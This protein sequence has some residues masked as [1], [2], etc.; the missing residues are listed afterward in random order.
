MSL[1]RS[2]SCCVNHYQKVHTFNSGDIVGSAPADSAVLNPVKSVILAPV[3]R[4]L[5]C[6]ISWST[7]EATPASRPSRFLPLTFCVQGYDH[8]IA[9]SDHA[10]GEHPA[11]SIRIVGYIFAGWITSSVCPSI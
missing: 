8:R 11:H 7:A 2:Q 1:E 6:F 5:A 9:S 10:R 3:K 4:R